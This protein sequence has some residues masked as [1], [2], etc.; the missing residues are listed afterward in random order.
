PEAPEIPT[1]SRCLSRA[2]ARTLP[3][4]TRLSRR[5]LP[6]LSGGYGR[7][8]VVSGRAGG[9]AMGD[10]IW[11]D[12]TLAT[13]TEGG[14]PFGLGAEGA[15]AIENGR[16]AWV[17]PKAA[18]PGEAASLARHVHDAGGRVL[19]PGLVDPHTHIVYGGDGLVDFELLT[20]GGTRADMIA[21]G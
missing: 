10:A 9:G 16:I 21:A 5:D 20:Q 19:T 8:S 6:R 4:G 13:R 14:A 2:M 17:G 1:M 18:L 15:I 11:V 3:P 7:A 12:A